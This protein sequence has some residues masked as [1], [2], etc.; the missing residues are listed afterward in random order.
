MFLKVEQ[1][2]TI[3]DSRQKEGRRSTSNKKAKLDVTAYDAVLTSLSDAEEVARKLQEAQQ[4]SF[5][6][7]NLMKP[8]ADLAHQC[9]PN[10]LKQR[11]P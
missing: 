7:S 1:A 6:I 2:E 3:V 4:V 5:C 9:H 8:H 10:L 11:W